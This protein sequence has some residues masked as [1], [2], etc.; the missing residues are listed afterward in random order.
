MSYYCLLNGAKVT[1]QGANERAVVMPIG[2]HLRQVKP[3]RPR[4]EGDS[5]VV[6]L[7]G[8]VATSYPSLIFALMPRLGGPIAALQQATSERTVR[9]S[10]SEDGPKGHAFTGPGRLDRGYIIVVKPQRQCTKPE[11]IGP[12]VRL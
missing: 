4:G 5:V 2:E 8:L 6:D 12:K 3:H 10:N 11:N 1:A 7:Y 9:N